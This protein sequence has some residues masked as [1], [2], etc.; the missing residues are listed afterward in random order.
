MGSL[1]VV[2]FFL[3]VRVLGGFYVFLEIDSRLIRVLA[4]I[5]AVADGRK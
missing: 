2:L 4:A 3:E 1:M 5:S